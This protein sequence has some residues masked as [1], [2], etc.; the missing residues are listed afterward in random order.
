MLEE[1]VNSKSKTF[2][3]FCFCFLFGVFLISIV[4]FRFNFVYLYL[5]LFI[6]ISLIIFF[7]SN[8][9]NVFL[10][11]CFLAFLL[12]IGRYL[13]AF[14]FQNLLE[15]QTEFGGYIVAEPDIRLDG[16][17]YIVESRKYKVESNSINVGKIY[18]KSSLYPRYNYGDELNIKCKLQRPEAMPDFRYDM[19]MAKQGIFL[20]CY[21]PIIEKVGEGNGSIVLSGIYKIKNSVAKKVNQLWPEPYASFMA[22]LLYG[23]RGGLGQ[24]SDSFNRTGITHIIAISGYNISIIG[25]VLLSIMSYLYIPRKKAF[26]L[27]VSG[28]VLFVIFAGTGGSVVRAGIMGILVL[29]AKQVGR[30]SRIFNVMIFT[31]VVM[32]LYNPLILV[33]DAGFQ[34]SFLAMIG[35]V[36]LSPMI[37]SLI[38]T[39]PRGEGSLSNTAKKAKGIAVFISKVKGSLVSLGIIETL[40]AIIITLPLILY[41]FGRLSIVAPVVN[42]LILWIIPFLMLF[43]FLAVLFSYIFYPLGQVV[44]W[45]GLVGLKYVIIVVQWFASLKFASIDIIIPVWVM[46]WM[47]GLLIY[48]LVKSRKYKV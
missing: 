13:L 14:P 36:Y 1:I 15:G 8:R 5:S 11:F 42:I 12:G 32:I 33:W 22:G 10:F 26:W 27:V 34:L 3:A 21:Q 17:G 2:L 7:W 9:R 18:F 19:F 37:G 41:Q 28:I 24:L 25:I 38:P 20:T 40:S 31:A 35:L 16:V 48:G 23:Y 29:L 44:A 6:I 45:I 39:T 30:L 4:D 43:G 47:Y 46:I